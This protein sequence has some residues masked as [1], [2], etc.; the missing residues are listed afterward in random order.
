MSD[1]VAAAA[2]L[3][4]TVGGSS[5]AEI[6]ELLTTVNGGLSHSESIYTSGGAEHKALLHAATIGH[7]QLGQY[8]AAR[9]RVVQLVGLDPTDQ[10]SIELKEMV[11]GAIEK[12]G[13]IGLAIVGGVVAAAA[14]TFAVLWRR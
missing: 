10:T 7:F 6:R 14:A 4:A 12:D 13:K 5:R 2:A 9:A 8:K 1:P 3:R 11:E